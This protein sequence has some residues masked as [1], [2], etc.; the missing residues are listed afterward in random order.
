MSIG[1]VKHGPE[2]YKSQLSN[3]PQNV[4]NAPISGENDPN[5]DEDS[6]GVC[7]L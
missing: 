4:K 6:H 7:N 3:V 2:S 5:Y 1:E